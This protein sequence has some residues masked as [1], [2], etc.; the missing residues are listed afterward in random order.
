MTPDIPL[1]KLP[2]NT[3][4]TDMLRDNATQVHA[5]QA[6]GRLPAYPVFV[7]RLFKQMPLVSV[8]GVA[9]LVQRCLDPEEGAL[10]LNMLA[11]RLRAL[12]A[13]PD[14]SAFHAAVGCAGEGGELLDCV[15]KVFIYGKS[16]ADRDAKTGQTPL[17]NLL[18]EMADF[19]FYYQKLLNMLGITDAQVQD[20]SYVKLSARYASGTYSDKQAQDRADKGSDRKFFGQER[21]K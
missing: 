2:L 4:F 9:E 11:E 12:A 1:H 16:W 15:K 10:D 21:R 8:Q 19:R 5:D 3:E 18:E 20:F 7:D 14:G 17:E 13:N 6:I